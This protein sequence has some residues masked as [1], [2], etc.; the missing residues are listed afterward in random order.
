M[1]RRNQSN[2]GIQK[3]NQN[4]KLKKENPNKHEIVRRLFNWDNRVNS[5]Q[6]SI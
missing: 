1:R 4:K 6:Q 5:I 2:V 3:P